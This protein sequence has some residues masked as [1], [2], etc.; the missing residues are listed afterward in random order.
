MCL[1]ANTMFLIEKHNTR[2]QTAAIQEE[3]FSAFSE[4]DTDGNGFLDR[5]ELQRVVEGGQQQGR[6][7]MSENEVEEVLAE[8]DASGDGLI[9][10]K[11]FMKVCV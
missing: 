9:D 7:L 3:L 5:E 1:Y 4:M 6:H 2:P 11:E 10:Y 8:L